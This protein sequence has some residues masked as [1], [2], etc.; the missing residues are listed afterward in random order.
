[1]QRLSVKIFPPIWGFWIGISAFVLVLI[2]PLS[3][4]RP[5]SAQHMLAIVLLMVIWWITEPIPLGITAL[6]PLILYPLLRIMPTSKVAPNYT[7]HLIFLFFGGF[8]ISIALQEWQLH[9]RFAL[10][11]LS[12][13]GN[14]PRKI[15][16]ALML[17]SG[18]ISMWLSNTATVLMLL[19]ISLA[20][21]HQ[22][23]ENTS[24]FKNG[25][26]KFAAVLLLAIAYGSSIGGIATPVGTPPNIIFLG[27]YAKF[28]PDS[29]LLS[30][31][32]WMLYLTPLST[33]LLIT[34][35]YY[36]G[37]IVLRKKDLPLTQSRDHFR[38]KYRELG[39]LNVP[40]KWVLGIFLLTAVMWIS[41]S[42]IDLE[43]I[44]FPGW[45]AL[46]GL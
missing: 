42:E 6:L 22:L 41:R 19:P 24:Q 15:L 30:F 31:S 7:D 26:F 25:P 13:L 3:A 32:Q 38:E 10:F 35:W 12:L 46:L 16:W 40:Q 27:I 20:L 2:Y 9:R 11:T 44:T 8:L 4:S 33:I 39:S 43:F 17:S 14:N 34:V 37:F 29:P 28:F 36:L 5:A 23:E 1:M 18:M 21:I 45:P